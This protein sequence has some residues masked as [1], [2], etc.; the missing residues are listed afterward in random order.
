MLALD[1]GFEH[2]VERGAHR[3]RDDLAPRFHDLAHIEVVEIEDAMDHVFLQL[4][5]VAGE[6]A[7]TDDQFQLFGGMA[8]TAVAASA[9][10]QVGQ[11]ARGAFDHRDENGGHAVEDA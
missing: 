5:Q 1:H 7:G 3:D 11:T 9:A 10:Q 6:T 2:L 4:G 8:A